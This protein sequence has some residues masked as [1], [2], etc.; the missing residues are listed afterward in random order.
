M[1]H[2]RSLVVAALGALFLAAV[3]ISV[4]SSRAQDSRAL[5]V[6]LLLWGPDTFKLD[7]IGKTCIPFPKSVTPA[8]IKIG[9]AELVLPAGI[10]QTT[11]ESPVG[12][13]TCE[14]SVSLSVPFSNSYVIEVDGQ[15]V[16]EIADERVQALNG[17]ITMA[18]RRQGNDPKLELIDMDWSLPTPAPPTPTPTPRPLP[19]PLPTIESGAV[20]GSQGVY[21]I[22]G[23]FELVGAQG[24][25]FAS[26]GEFG[27]VGIGGYADIVTGKQVIIRNQSGDII[28]TAEFE[29]DPSATTDQCRFMFIAEVPDATFY[30][31]E[32]GRRGELAYSKQELQDSDWRVTL[33]LGS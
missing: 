24:T 23:S 1:Q 11:N 30:S 33:T 10:H 5:N 32:I 17:S 19:T 15:R 3:L 12:K 29:P 20:E 22:V 25:E 13:V 7:V 6:H 14:I 4:G 18:V 21:R 16:G 27:C 8:T 28:A 9:S 2:V 26:L 31:F